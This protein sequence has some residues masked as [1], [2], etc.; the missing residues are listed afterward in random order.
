[1]ILGRAAAL[2]ELTPPAAASA[3]GVSLR[4]LE[5][6]AAEAGI[7][8]S[9]VRRA[10]A[11]LEV[12]PTEPTA[13]SILLGFPL[14]VSLNYSAP[15]ELSPT[16]FPRLTDL[17]QSQLDLMGQTQALGASF[18][19]HPV[20]APRQL[21]I[22]IA[23]EGGRTVIRIRER[24]HPLV[25]GLFGGIIG[26]AGGGLG[27]A[28]AGLIGGVLGSLWGALL[29]AAAAVLGSWWLARSIFTRVAGRRHQQLADLGAELTEEI[30]RLT[31][32]PP[33]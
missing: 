15:G 14:N 22:S 5:Q 17:I 4:D 26:G 9:L 33:P 3:E 13:A 25:G 24:L 30:Q 11:E 16:T 7:D 19:W 21:L 23:P 12:R 28:A 1:M 18:R 2:Q 27:G 10:A 31:L 29:A 6:V 32:P 8:A 20:A